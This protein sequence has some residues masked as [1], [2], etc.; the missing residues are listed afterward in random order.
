MTISIQDGAVAGQTVPHVHV[1]LLPRK[2]GDFDPPDKVYDAID[3]LDLASVQANHG[4]GV[5][6]NVQK[7]GRVIVDDELR[8]ARGK[9]EMRKEAEELSLLF[10]AESRGEFSD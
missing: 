7:K 10:P 9:P 3:S 4:E 8:F 2:K 5:Q 1:H 6:D